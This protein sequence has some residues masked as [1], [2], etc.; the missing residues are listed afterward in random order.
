MELDVEEG[1][2]AGHGAQ[3]AL[4]PTQIH[5]VRGA[6]GVLVLAELDGDQAIRAPRYQLVLF[7]KK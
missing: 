3:L 2:L 7:S 4:A 5:A 6:N 1:R